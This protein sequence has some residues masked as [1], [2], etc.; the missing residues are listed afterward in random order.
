MYFINFGEKIKLFSQEERQSIQSQS[1][2]SLSIN[3]L[4]HT[5]IDL[6]VTF[7]HWAVKAVK[8]LSFNALGK[9]LHLVT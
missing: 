6:H 5:A 2:V 7:D 3:L 9:M 1:E 4:I 8:I